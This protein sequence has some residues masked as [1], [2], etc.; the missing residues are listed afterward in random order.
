MDGSPLRAPD[1][2]VPKPVGRTCLDPD[3]AVSN[4]RSALPAQTAFLSASSLHASKANV[5]AIEFA[6]KWQF[7][8]EAWKWQ[9][10]E[11]ADVETAVSVE[12][13]AADEATAAAHALASISQ[14]TAIAATA[15][16][17]SASAIEGKV[18]PSKLPGWPHM[19]SRSPM[20]PHP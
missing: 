6:S 9:P 5:P 12:Q 7:N 3:A 17:V 19:H 1:S 11:E 8:L 20:R 14:R 4:T 10:I 15:N 13:P 18:S 16:R 2:R